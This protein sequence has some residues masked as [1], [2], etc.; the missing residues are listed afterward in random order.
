MSGPALSPELAE[1]FAGNGPASSEA[2]E[3]LRP[4]RRIPI[5]LRSPP[6]APRVLAKLVYVGL[7]TVL[8]SE[9][10]VGKSWLAAWL[11]NQLMSDGYPVIFIDEEGGP[12]LVTERLLALG[13]DPDVVAT[14]FH[15]FAFESR[16]WGDEDLLALDSLIS[17]VPGCALAV[18]DS[19]PDFLAA[20]QLSEDSA[21]DVTQFVNTVCRRFRDAGIA[22][23]LLDHPP[24]PPVEGKAKR[25]RYSR[26]SGAKLAK[27]DATLLAESV[28]QFDAHTSG[29]LQIW[30]TKDRRGRLEVPWHTQR[31]LE[32]LV[33]VAAGAVTIEPAETPAAPTWD[34]PT[35]CMAAVLA[36]LEAEA[37]D[38]MTGN[39]LIDRLRA[40]GHGFRDKT[41]R[42]AAERL[43]VDGKASMRTGR[44]NARLFS[45]KPSENTQEVPLDEAL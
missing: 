1:L 41:V 22:Q 28:E 24:K 33:T 9:P 2:V 32:L 12:E 30:K 45:W 38:E 40:L 11:A 10:G 7:L 42:E 43:A 36:V 37:P 4:F 29:R 31:G 8:Q 34:G 19:L 39:A 21:T 25:S 27:A 35:E 3:V 44:N 26:G 6:H 18:L 13:A 23:L 17:S 16:R 20:A 5:D 14:L 15:Y